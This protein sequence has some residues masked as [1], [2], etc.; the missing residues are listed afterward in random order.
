MTTSAAA[1]AT[2]AIAGTVAITKKLL[3]R[4]VPHDSAITR[5]EFH[6]GLD[7]MRDRIGAS[8]LAI[9]DKLDT[10]HR[11]LLSALDRQVTRINDLEAGFARLDERT[12][13]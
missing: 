2:A 3:P 6:Q 12:K 11:E 1:I 5:A 13:L 7:S 10:N 4:K 9:A 8:Y